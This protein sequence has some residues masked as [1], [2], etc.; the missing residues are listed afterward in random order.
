MSGV[1][2]RLDRD[3]L[4]EVARLYELVA[5]SGSRT[6]PPGLAR[7]FEDTLFDHPWADEEIPSLVSEDAG[8]RIVGFLASH[9][10]RMEMAGRSIRV[11]CSGHVVTEP[12]ARNRAIGLFLMRSYMEGAQDLT[13]TDTAGPPVRRMWESLGGETSQLN[14]VGWVRVFRPAALAADVASRQRELG[15]LEKATRPLQLALDAAGVGLSKTGL[16]P[17]VPKGSTEPLTAELIAEH[18]PAVARQFEL[19]P[20]YEDQGFVEWLLREVAAVH[21]RG[22]LTARLVR[23]DDGR[24]RGW[25]V[26][27]LQPE[28]T[29]Q[30]LQVAC[31]ERDADDVVDALLH[32][33]FSQGAAGAQGRL[34]GHLMRALSERRCLLHRAGYI[35]LIHGRDPEVLH[36]VQAGRAMLTRLEGEWWMG[37]HLE[38]FTNEAVAA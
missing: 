15:R 18:L 12:D 8:G 16:Q 3:D 27:Y 28:R 33:A 34:E 20:A 23:G 17:P 25:F 7:H 35:A 26:Y 29:A 1:T 6:A 10:R 2:R 22:P 38:P 9:V 32:D 4:E 37:H 14:C 31:S 21:S 19:R 36:A 5:R 11:G 30:V 13:F 24:V